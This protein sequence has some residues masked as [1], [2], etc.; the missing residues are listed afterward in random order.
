M[1]PKWRWPRSW[2]TSWSSP[3]AG[4]PAMEAPTVVPATG[5]RS[6]SRPPKRRLLRS[7][8]STI[9]MIGQEESTERFVMT[10]FELPL[11]PSV[12]AMPE[13]HGAALIVGDNPLADVLRHRLQA[14]GVTVR[15]LRISENID[16]T[17]AA[18]ERIWAEQPTP[19]VFI[20]TGRDA[21]SERSAGRPPP[22][23][24]AGTARPSCRYFLCQRFIQLAGEAKHAQ[25]VQ[26]GRH[27]LPGRR[28]RH[29]GQP[30][31]PGERG[32]AGLL[33]AI[34][35]EV[36]AIR[37][38]RPFRATAIDARRGRAAGAPGRQHLPRTGQRRQRFRSGLRR[39]HAAAWATP[40][41]RRLRCTNTPRSA[42]AA[43]G[44]S[45]AG[46]AGSRPLCALELG[47]RFGVKLHLIGTS[48]LRAI[49]P[50]WRSLSADDMKTLK[51]AG[52]ARGPC[53]RP[54]DG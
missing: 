36:G 43:S 47:K 20:T 1:A 7:L 52:D 30:A 33:K 11:E 26:P 8:R 53:R 23:S 42:R 24:G 13:W 10:M 18:F 44:C 45:P 28:L 46:P 38:L 51:T 37:G 48:P 32:L 19:H 9:S 54:L 14:A 22:G 41:R 21:R 5:H 2:P 39:R 25:A 4:G 50:A 34:H 31:E 49:D 35:V 6:V 27:H 3:R 15:D 16:E 29:R 40:F 12:P 17:V